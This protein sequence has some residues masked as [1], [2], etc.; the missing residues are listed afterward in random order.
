MTA[1]PAASNSQRRCAWPSQA[2]ADGV[3]DTCLLLKKLRSGAQF[4]GIARAEHALEKK[5]LNAKIGYLQLKVHGRRQANE[6]LM[7]R[8]Q[9]L[10]LMLHKERCR[11]QVT[12]S[13]SSRAD[14]SLGSSSL[15]PHL[16]TSSMPG[17][18]RL[19]AL[20]CQRK[21]S[22]SARTILE[23]AHE[24]IVQSEDVG[25]ATLVRD[26]APP[27]AATTSPTPRA[28]ST[29]AAGSTSL[30]EG[31]AARRSFEHQQELGLLPPAPPVLAP[32][33]VDPCD[34]HTS[35][36]ATSAALQAAPPEVA[37]ESGAEAAV[38][39]VPAPSLRAVREEEALV[40]SLPGDESR[41]RAEVRGPRLVEG[42]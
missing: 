12:G 13:T 38:A 26:S 3:D 39:I 22:I 14:H 34:L 21:S 33:N 6:A 29:A 10:E 41:E 25:D 40:T 42:T 30:E 16:S 28:W 35:T 5:E 18:A 9:M 8:V 4:S 24:T 7:R 19:E 17:R 23:A 37:E 31:T 20:L 1:L 27:P 2:H 15:P 11:G 36:A 32:Q